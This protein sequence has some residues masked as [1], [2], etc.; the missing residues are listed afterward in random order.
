SDSAFS[1]DIKDYSIKNSALTYIDMGSNMQFYLTELN[2]SGKGTFSGDISELDTKSEANVS[3]TMD[4]TNYLKNNPVKLDALIGMDLNAQN[5]LFK[6]NQ[7][8]S[9]QLPINFDRFV[10]LLVDGQ[11]IHIAFTNT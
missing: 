5:Y 2:H 7:A 11:N 10:Q 9:K 4:S 8:Q 3:F 6:E 1:F